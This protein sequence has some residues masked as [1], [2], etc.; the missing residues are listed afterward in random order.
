MGFYFSVFSGLWLD[1]TVN[2]IS[3]LQVARHNPVQ[4]TNFSF[5]NETA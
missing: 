2:E 5:E 3:C 1:F 4:Q